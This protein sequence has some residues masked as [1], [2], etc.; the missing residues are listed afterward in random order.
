M[1]APMSSQPEELGQRRGAGLARATAAHSSPLQGGGPEGRDE[2]QGGAGD[3]VA[4]APSGE[5]KPRAEP[6]EGA[7]T[8]TLTR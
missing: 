7:R 1:A 6:L 5:P 8:E 3:A 4:V 2:A